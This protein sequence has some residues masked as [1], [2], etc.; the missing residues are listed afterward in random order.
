M[1]SPLHLVAHRA[2]RRFLNFRLGWQLLRHPGVPTGKKVLAVLVGL[3]VTG[4]LVA[5]EIPLEGVLG[6]LAPGVGFV[7]DV[8]I[9]GAEVFIL[10]VLIATALMPYMARVPVNQPLPTPGS[11][12]R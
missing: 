9:D 5:C 11:A 6:L 2:T 12:P 1:P 7:A 3:G 4:A 8:A 10:P